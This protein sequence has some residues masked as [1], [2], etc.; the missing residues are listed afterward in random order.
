[1]P[2]AN[3]STATEPSASS[4]PDWVRSLTEIFLAG[5]TST[6]VL[7]GNVH[8]LVPQTQQGGGVRYLSLKRYLERALF[9]RF[10]CVA[11]YDR[12]NVDD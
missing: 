4:S 6:F 8:D 1:M 7:H 3:D 11:H 9:P 5:T 10:D 12:G 2:K